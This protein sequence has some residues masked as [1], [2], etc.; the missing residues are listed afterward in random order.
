LDE[1]KQIIRETITYIK[2]SELKLVPIF[3]KREVHEQ[4]GDILSIYCGGELLNILLL[5]ILICLCSA[6]KAKQSHY[7][8]W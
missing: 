5:E 1:L 7:M 8:S 6:K 2:V 4:K 3:F